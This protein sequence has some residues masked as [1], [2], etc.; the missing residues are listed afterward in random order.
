QVPAT[1]GCIIASNHASFIDPPAV[2][3]GVWHRHVR[4]MARETLF[5]NPLT[6]WWAGAVGVVP[7]DRTKGDIAAMRM[8][9]NVLKGGGVLALFPEGTRTRDG[10]L[11]R[12]KGGVGFLIAR[13][14]VPVVPAFVHGSFQALPR[15][16][17]CVRPRK[18]AV[19]YGAP[20]MPEELQNIMQGEKRYQDVADFVMRRIAELE[21]QPLDAGGSA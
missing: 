10:K 13:S 21:N 11:Q 5:K 12:V 19:V 9:L 8:A 1:G 7:L 18:V 17:L 16:A 14:G 2:V 6:R 20:I 15:G 4:F 3:C